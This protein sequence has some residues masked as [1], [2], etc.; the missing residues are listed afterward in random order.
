[1]QNLIFTKHYK[2]NDR[3]RTSFFKLAADTFDID[4]ERWYQQGGWSEHYIP[5]SFVDGNEIVANASVNTV[6]L[7][8]SGQRKKAIQIGTV[9]THPDYRGQRAYEAN[10]ISFHAR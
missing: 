7:V 8:I 9:M 3:L 2:N 5:F 4:F 6:E 1:M 10:Y